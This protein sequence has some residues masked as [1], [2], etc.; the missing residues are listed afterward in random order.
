MV[1]DERDRNTALAKKLLSGFLTISLED[2]TF[3]GQR[4][5][6][7][8]VGRISPN[9]FELLGI[10]PNMEG[11]YDADGGSPCFI[12]V[13]SQEGIPLA[14]KVLSSQIMAETHAFGDLRWKE[15][16]KRGLDALVA[17]GQIEK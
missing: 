15:R 13:L 3:D 5:I 12:V 14:A 8:A 11:P 16:L 6:R 9:S 4:D 2:L 7:I 1:F 17:D 10:K